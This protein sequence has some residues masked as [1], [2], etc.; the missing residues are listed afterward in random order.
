[1]SEKGFWE[2]VFDVSI[3]AEP[4][5]DFLMITSGVIAISFIV[6]FVFCMIGLC[7]IIHKKNVGKDE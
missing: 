2:Q 6:I 4:V 1:M 7:S 5:R 3:W